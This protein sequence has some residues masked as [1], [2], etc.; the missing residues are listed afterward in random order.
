MTP[1]K[2]HAK[3]QKEL[4]SYDHKIITI[5]ARAG[6]NYAETEAYKEVLKGMERIRDKY[7]K[8]YPSISFNI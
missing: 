1:E 5:I 4:S 6:D 8:K 2:I 3:Y 7:R